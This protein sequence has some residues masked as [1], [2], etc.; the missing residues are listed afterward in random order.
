MRAFT[1]YALIVGGLDITKKV[2]RKNKSGGRGKNKDMGGKNK[3]DGRM[4]LAGSSVD[5]PRKVVQKTRRIRKVKEKDATSADE[6]SNKAL[7]RINVPETVT[8]SHFIALT[9]EIP[10]LDIG[11]NENNENVTE[12]IEVEQVERVKKSQGWNK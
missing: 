5:G 3:V 8:G 7:A 6:G 11:V 9:A 2:V 10:N 12:S 1:S 4:E